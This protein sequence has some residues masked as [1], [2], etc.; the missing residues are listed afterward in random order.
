M[1]SDFGYE[2]TSL[3]NGFIVSA[4]SDR[5]PVQVTLQPWAWVVAPYQGGGFANK[6]VGLVRTKHLV[7]TIAHMLR[8][9]WKSRDGKTPHRRV[10]EWAVGR[11]ARA[12]HKRT[13][14]E[15]E[16]LL[17]H[18]PQEVL[19]VQRAVF[20]AT[21][22]T[23]LASQPELYESQYAMLRSDIKRYRA[24]A[25]ALNMSRELVRDSAQRQIRN[26]PDFKALETRA[27][28]LGLQMSVSEKPLT[29]LN[30]HGLSMDQVFG[31]LADDWKAL[32][33]PDGRP[34]TSLNRT[35]MNI[36][37]GVP[38]SLLTHLAGIQLPR[39]VTDRVE[40]LSLLTARLS[41]RERDERRRHF[42]VFVHASR[43]QLIKAIRIV[44]DTTHQPLSPRRTADIHRF[45]SYLMDYPDDHRGTVVGLARRSIR[46][47]REEQQ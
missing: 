23:G 14:V 40:L 26:S 28:E 12:I 41:V 36:P 18:V 38:A 21:F 45:V 33:S 29:P 46:W 13:M 11:T 24:A 5:T 39:P 30:P 25:M 20:A 27:S 1:T 19:D 3:D 17:V 6:L 4:P 42:E 35:L 34:Y 22:A 2:F 10:H 7:D 47:H 9:D 43:E 31:S 15:V 32:F 16:R 37:G 8:M 44:A